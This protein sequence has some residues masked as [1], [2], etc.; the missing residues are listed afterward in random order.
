MI[1]LRAK[2]NGLVILLLVGIVILAYT[3]VFYVKAGNGTYTKQITF[4]LDL[5][6]PLFRFEQNQFNDS[7][8]TQ[9]Y[10][11][12]TSGNYTFWIELPKNSTINTINMNMNLTGKILANITNTGAALDHWS[13]DIGNLTDNSGNE[14]VISSYILTANNTRVYDRGMNFLWGYDVDNDVF[15]VEIG[16]ITS[17][18]GNELVLGSNSGVSVLNSSGS[19]VWDNSLGQAKS[20]VIGNLTSEPGNEVIAGGTSVYVLN[21]SGD[22]VDSRTLGNDTYAVAIGDVN[23][24]IN[25]NEVVAGTRGDDD[26]V[27]VLNRTL[28]TVWSYTAEYDINNVE[29]GNITSDQGNEIVAVGGE[30]GSGKV[31]VL[32]ASGSSVWNYTLDDEG[33]D[34]AIGEVVSSHAG[35]E[36]VVA[37]GGGDADNR[38]YI[39]N[40]TG[41]LILSY[42]ASSYVRGVAI[43]NISEDSGDNINETLA[44][45]VDGNLYELNYDNF[46][47]N[48]TI[49]V[50]GNASWNYSQGDRRLRTSAVVNGLEEEIQNFLD[51]DTLCPDNICNVTFNVSSSGKGIINI[52]E[53]NITYDYNASSNIDNTS[54]YP[55]W[56]RN[57]GV[58]VNESIISEAINI[59]YTNPALDI[60][61]RYIRIN[62]TATVCG[63]KN[64]TYSNTT[65]NGANYCNITDENLVVY[66]N[67]GHAPTLLWDNNM[68]SDVPVFMHVSAPYNTSG[69]DNNYWRKNFT[70]TSNASEMF[71]NI[72]ANVSINDSVVRGGVF[73]NVSW[74]GTWYDITPSTTC[75][76]MDSGLVLGFIGCRNDTDGDG[77]TDY[78]NF[79]QPNITAMDNV[80]Y[81]AGGSFN[82]KPDLTDQNV[83]PSSGYWGQ[84]YNFSVYVNDTEGNNVNVTLWF[85]YNFSDSWV[86]MGTE[87]ITGSGYVYFNKTSERSWVGANKYKFEYQDFN[88]SGYPVHSA[89]NTSE[90]TGPTVLRH[91]VTVTHISGNNSVVYRE[92]RSLTGN[93]TLILQVMI[94]DTTDYDNWT[95]MNCT[96]WVTQNNGSGY[97]SGSQASLNDSGYC[98]ITF[99][100]DSGYTVGGQI[101]NTTVNET[102]YL[103]VNWT[104]FTARIKGHLNVSIASPSE[105]QTIVRNTNNIY[106][107]RLIDEYG[108]GVSLSGYNCTWYFNGSD[109]MGEN[110]TNSTG[111]CILN[112]TA[113]CTYQNL[114]LYYLN[115][116]LN[117]TQPAYYTILGN[118]SS[119]SVALID[120]SS[121]V[122]DLPSAGTF[123]NKNQNVSL[124]S[125]VNDS[126]SSCSS[127]QY[128]ITW[129]GIWKQKFNITFNETLGI[130]RTNEVI[131]LKGSELSDEDVNLSAWKIN[132]TRII[133]E[134]Q[135]VSAQINNNSAD[136]YIAAESE[137]IFLLNLSANQTKT[138]EFYFDTENVFANTSIHFIRNGG[139]ESG[140]SSNWS[141]SGPTQI[142]SGGAANG[143]YSYRVGNYSNSVGQINQ[144]FNLTSSYLHMWLNVSHEDEGTVLVTLYN[145]TYYVLE[146]FG[147][148]TYDYSGFENHTGWIERNYNV[149]NFTGQMVTLIITANAST[150]DPTNDQSE[151]Y[152]DS[153]CMSDSSGTCVSYDPGSRTDLRVISKTI[154]GSEQNSTWTV[155]VDQDVGP[156]TILA[157]M[158]GSYYITSKN[159]TD[160]YIYGWSNVSNISFSPVVAGECINYTCLVNAS[161][162]LYCLV[163]DANTSEGIY[164]YSV[165]F[166]RNGTEIGNATTNQSGWASYLW[167]NSTSVEGSHEIKCNISDSMATYYNITQNNSMNVNIS[168]SANDTTG[169]LTITPMHLEANNLT[170]TNNV[171]VTFNLTI[172]N[173]GN[174]IMYGIYILV[175]NK[176]N[177]TSSYEA[178]KSLGSLQTCDGN[179]SFDI[180]RFADLGNTSINVSLRWSNPVGVF[181]NETVTI[182]VINNT[183]L[184]AAEDAINITLAFGGTASQNITIEAFGNTE[185]NSVNLSKTGGD[186]ATVG[187]WINFSQN[188]FAVSRFGNTTVSVGISVPD[189]S[190]N[191]GEYSV[192]ILANDT[193]SDCSGAYEN[194]TDYILLNINV[195]DQDWSVSPVSDNTITAGINT[196][197]LGYF[198]L[199]NITNRETYNLTIN[200]TLTSNGTQFFNTTF[201]FN[202]TVTPLPA[203]DPLNITNRSYGYLNVTYNISNATLSDVGL[204]YM[205]IS[206]QNMNSSGVPAYFNLT[207]WLE[208]S[209]LEIV[210]IYPNASSPATNINV[211]DTIQITANATYNGNPLTENMTFYAEV[212]GVHCP[213]TSNTTSGDLWH[214]NCTAPEIPGNRINNT[215]LL[216]GNYTTQNM[217]FNATQADSVVYR[218]VT[219][220][221]INSIDLFVNG[222]SSL[223]ADNDPNINYYT[224]NVTN[225][226]VNVNVTDN[227]NVSNV[228][229][230]VTDPDGNSARINLTNSGGDIWT[231]NYTN[232]R[233]IGDYRINV[234]ANDSNSLQNSTENETMGWFDIYTEIE[235]IGNF[236]D[237]DGNAFSANLTFYKPGTSWN[238]T[239]NSSSGSYNFTIHNRSYDIVVEVFDYAVRLYNVNITASA[240]N[241]FN[242]TN[243]GNITNAI[244]FDNFPNRSAPDISNIDLP[245]TAENILMAF[246]ISAPYLSYS[247][248][249]INVTYTDA[250]TAGTFEEPDLRIF[251]CTNWNYGSRTCSGGDFDRFNN[252]NDIPNVTANTFSFAANPGTAYA[253][254]ESCYPNTCGES[255][256]SN[257]PGGGYVPSGGGG[258]TTYVCGNGRCES[259][260][261]ALNCPED[262]GTTSPDG[263]E[264]F[265][266]RTTMIEVRIFPGQNKS[267]P[268]W[269][270]NNMNKVKHFTISVEGSAQDFI[271][272]RDNA[273]IVAANDTESTDILIKTQENSTLGTY[274]GNIVVRT[275]AG[276]RKIPVTIIITQ[277][278]EI[279][280]DL[281]VE[282]RT[283]QVEPAGILQFH[284]S[285]YNTGRMAEFDT[286]LTYIVSNIETGKNTTIGNETV[287]VKTTRSFTKNINL[288][289]FNLS[290]GHYALEVVA[291]YEGGSTISTDSFE[292]V[293]AFWTPER[294][295][296]VIIIILI[297]AGIIA[298][299]YTWKRYLKWKMTKARYVFPLDYK[300]LPKKT[301]ESFWIGKVAETDINTYFNSRDVM[302]HILIGGATGSGKSVTA[303]IFAEEALK[304]N[305]PVIVF[306]PTA[307]WTGF[308]RPCRDKNLLK[309]YSKFG[310][311]LE[312]ARPFKGII[313]EVTNPNIKIDFRKLMKPGEITVFTLNKLKPDQYDDAVI[314]IIDTMFG[315][316]WEESTEL[317]MMMIFDEVHRLLEKYGG[318]GGYIALEKATRE[319]RKWGIGLIMA[320]QVS[321]DFKEAIMGNVLTEIQLNTKSLNDIKK[322]AKKYGEIYSSRIT[323]ESVGVGMIQ[324]PKYNK[325]KPYFVNFRPTLH[326]PHK[327]SETE[328]GMYKKYSIIVDKIES[329]ILSL[330]RRGVDTTDLELEI[331][332]VK[333]KLKEGRFRMVEIYVNLLKKKLKI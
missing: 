228:W 144:T 154:I 232:P 98:N 214:I 292:V 272:F 287:N 97:D 158:N 191:M 71:R 141:V 162:N 200:F 266:V 80:S 113:D 184:N 18:P 122:I 217:V 92:N 251:Y 207:R 96:F 315:I 17:D 319:F 53:L 118:V 195:T 36:I 26:K 69:T 105:N 196:N 325:G 170:K 331:G 307:Q 236:T 247:S 85:Y 82:L 8:Y 224:E 252:E 168:F 194:C 46:P 6:N 327:I 250:L 93:S 161:I 226:T 107:A 16:N 15:D 64:S 311:R 177:F 240:E 117:G 178:C 47:I 201:I 230:N 273:L 55:S 99:N 83:T 4:N 253:I 110:Q 150:V 66:A 190:S 114:G 126:C 2:R 260:E 274:T 137:I 239:G 130:N 61:I 174:D 119:I 293:A 59:S 133:C 187:G 213:V 147:N 167:I 11:Y 166:Y 124:N 182:N 301:D 277:A 305:I 70:I 7:S 77:I 267:Y 152:V 208:I 34:V 248:A 22:L 37:G 102:Y 50:G 94:N 234:Y 135:N 48:I 238:I 29:I 164:N 76:A 81:Q 218:D 78:F 128:N 242:T 326:S 160:V 159:T 269:V 88:S 222:T 246:V 199:I 281:V 276:T 40:S 181:E 211:S 180:T 212:G 157:K 306:D 225:I 215:L 290:L 1:S 109:N 79:T 156:Q 131:T 193:G 138:C 192:Y 125:S 203:S 314:N 153:V 63:L 295:T 165:F 35:N 176:T 173:T 106:Q 33:N 143:T 255:P 282:A 52:S 220:P 68:R 169:N 216:S 57:Y 233:I 72:S 60:E 284:I 221:R 175:Y 288:A 229:I 163:L 244:R 299:Y 268:L 62:S 112:W 320:S 12:N 275:D 25:G 23:T 318:K 58:A 43:G 262:C 27:Y 3:S 10:Q 89:T 136:E 75:P 31:Y 148:D 171:S 259:G 313:V 263:E 39:I 91:N 84:G 206:I 231:G 286:N 5:S 28:G 21:S 322:V 321:S 204:Y 90:F 183:I 210:I 146:K 328:M 304:R 172:N 140:D 73:L 86:N 235:F 13:V 51:N 54:V 120:N 278:G 310:M 289:E 283:R 256:P 261:N 142:I 121:A 19:L 209:Q 101:W 202:N 223:T 285:M 123:F 333:D 116:T 243:P 302:T 179:L 151:V 149:S 20:V 241:M 42:A 49:Y 14:I 300:K 312:E 296:I 44:V 265:D 270:T 32:N 188:D 219:P 67:S 271:T 145:G 74:G 227:Y 95:G 332:L 279:G 45:D 56:S 127:N 185:L 100:P 38:I 103:L 329:K 264:S 294:V 303:S 108:S 198:S 298:G 330:K 41:Q 249:I 134:G 104:N 186:S 205:N 316:P 323:H 155:P 245:D 258:T 257:P 309:F 237:A 308:V 139:F 291:V 30:S 87:N 24:F 189:N 132:S 324:N 297:I 197:N 317:K 129:F 65:I 115:V 9:E 280:L 254:A 111:Y